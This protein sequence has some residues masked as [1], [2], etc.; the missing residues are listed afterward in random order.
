MTV[1]LFWDI[2]GTL[3]STARGGVFAL[4][5]AIAEMAGAPVELQTLPTAGLT[6]GQIARLVLEAAGA[7]CDDEAVSR[8]LA[9]YEAAL[10]EAL[11]RRTGTVLPGVR[12]V[13]ED[14]ADDERVLSLLLTGNTRAG[15]RAKLA[16]YGLDDLLVDG[17]F[18]VGAGPREE[19]AREA[20]QRAEGRLGVIPDP[21]TTFVI[22][23][24]PHDI[25]CANAIGARTV[26]VATGGYSRAELEAHDAWMVLDT[27]PAPAVFRELLGLGRRA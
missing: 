24:T 23:D 4:E 25:R 17:A 3:L 8:F 14:L 19:I 26:A 16:H 21:A 6:D 27:L 20:V 7:A 9:I 10:P 1:V 22:G 12:E 13:L 5:A 15:A 11:G 2:D 18:C